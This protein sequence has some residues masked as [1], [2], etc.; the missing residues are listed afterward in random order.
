MIPR[1]QIGLVRI[2]GTR[3]HS[4]TP[5][6]TP[7]TLAADHRPNEGIITEVKALL[8]VEE[9]YGSLTVSERGPFLVP[10]DSYMVAG[11]RGA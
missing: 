3:T 8:V 4:L 7:G 10:I 11:F 5:L 6:V 2:Q 1:V 9:L